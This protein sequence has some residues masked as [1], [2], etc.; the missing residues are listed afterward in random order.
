MQRGEGG[1]LTFGVFGGHKEK[2]NR[3]SISL[4]DDVTKSINIKK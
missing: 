4:L 2:G 3:G 1:A